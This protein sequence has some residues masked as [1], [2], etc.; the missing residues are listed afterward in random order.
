MLDESFINFRVL[1][2]DCDLYFHM[3]NA[4]HTN[5]AVLGRVYHLGK[6][7]VDMLFL[8]RRWFPVIFASETIFIKPFRPFKKYILKTKMLTRD[9]KYWYFEHLFEVD[10]I[11]HA[12]NLSMGVLLFR[13]KVVS[14]NEVASEIGLPVNPPKLPERIE[15]WKGLHE[16]IKISA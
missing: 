3:N 4:R 6:A 13:G 15:K 16:K 8:K 9:D 14:L 10:E 1:P 11:T 7:G 12:I 2:N 5:I